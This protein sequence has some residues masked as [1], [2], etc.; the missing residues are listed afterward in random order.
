MLAV[1]NISYYALIKN[2]NIQSIY[3]VHLAEVKPTAK[4][5]QT[6]VKPSASTSSQMSPKKNIKTQGDNSSLGASGTSTNDK[7]SK[8]VGNPGWPSKTEN[9]IITPSNT[10]SVTKGR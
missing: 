5:Q 8:S 3:I 6:K 7:P 2:I 10:S 1:Y 4:D 9:P